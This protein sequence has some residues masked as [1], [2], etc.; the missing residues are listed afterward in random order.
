MDKWKSDYIVRQ[1]SR[2]GSMKKKFELAVVIP[3]ITNDLNSELKPVLQ[4]FVK[5]KPSN[6]NAYIDLFYPGIKLAIEIDEEYHDSRQVEDIER[7]KEIEKVLDC[8][9][10]RVDTKTE[11]F[12]INTAINDV[13][14]VISKKLAE[15]KK[16]GLFKEWLKP[17]TKKLDDILSETKNTIVLKTIIDKNGAEVLPYNRIS[18]EVRD[19]AEYVI[20]FSG[21][22]EYND[23]LVGYLSFHADEYLTRPENESFVSPTGVTINDSPYLNVNID[24]WKENR[25][26]AYSKD[27]QKFAKKNKTR[28]NNKKKKGKDRKK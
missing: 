19:N 7:Q 2:L 13:N 16:S 20:A 27:L 5:R 28:Q 1:I 14:N 4:Q 6:K 18:Q 24:S 9:F 22:S 21:S 15:T 12:N 26:I 8:T 11:T 23:A 10:F 25:S 17:P 3:V